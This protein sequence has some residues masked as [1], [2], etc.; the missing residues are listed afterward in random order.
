MAGNKLGS[1][2]KFVYISDDQSKVYILNRDLDL[3]VG[4]TGSGDAAPQ[5]ADGFT[6]SGSATIAGAPKGFEPR[7]VNII[8]RTDGAK[9]AL[10]CFSPNS[11]LYNS[12]ESKD[13]VIDGV[14]FTTTGRSGETQTF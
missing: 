5:S 6:P 8:D 11:S 3:A 14:T 13:V 4:G 10:I 2:G 1:K 7:K 9:K 12:S